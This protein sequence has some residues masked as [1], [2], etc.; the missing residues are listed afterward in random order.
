MDLSYLVNNAVILVICTI[1]IIKYYIPLR[2]SVEELRGNEMRLNLEYDTLNERYIEATNNLNE[3]INKNDLLTIQK[4]DLETQIALSQ[5]KFKHLSTKI[6]EWDK[7][8]VQVVEQ[9]KA[10]VF[11]VGAKLSKNLIDEHKRETQEFAQINKQNIHQTTSELYKQFESVITS[12][13]MIE[14]RVTESSNVTT[15]IKQALLHPLKYGKLAEISLENILK[16]S[17]LLPQKDFFIQPSIDHGRKRP[18]A[19][20]ALPS[21]NVMIIDCKASQYFVELSDQSAE[22]KELLEKIT[23]SLHNHLKILSGKEYKDSVTEYYH[24]HKN[25]KYNIVNTIMFL[26]SD[27]VL[28]KI[29]KMVPEFM[30]KA[31]GAGV[32]PV[33]PAGLLS[34]LAYAKFQIHNHMQQENYLNIIAE[35]RKLLKSTSVMQEHS[36]K[37]GRSLTQSISHYDKFA[38]SFNS[39]FVNSARKLENLGVDMNKSKTLKDKSLQPI[40]SHVSEEK[41]LV[42]GETTV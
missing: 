7:M 6:E 10:A 24:D 16:D 20:I 15:S 14:Q 30:E 27:S 1:F 36:S 12:M 4:H 32:L 28:E 11:D 42:S 26:P 2:R 31:W 17:G 37:L 18:D 29:W 39:S 33:G 34:M 21:D 5:E 3:Y 8:Q 13:N 40:Q 19:I 9:A 35:I 22:N 25:K 38:A 41:E 23:K